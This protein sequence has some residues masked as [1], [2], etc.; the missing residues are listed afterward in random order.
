MWCLNLLSMEAL[1]NA[2]GRRREVG[3][4]GADIRSEVQLSS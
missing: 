3:E 2:A 4:A 1:E